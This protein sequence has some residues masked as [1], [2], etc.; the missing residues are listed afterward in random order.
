VIRLLAMLRQKGRIDETLIRTLLG[1]RHF[2]FSVQDDARVWSQG[3]AEWRG[4][5]ESALRSPSCQKRA[6]TPRE[7]PAY[8][9]TPA[10]PIAGETDWIITVIELPKAISDP[11]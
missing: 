6:R 7:R 5:A 11:G 4:V 3:V 9:L 10:Y 2:G 1:W 8:P